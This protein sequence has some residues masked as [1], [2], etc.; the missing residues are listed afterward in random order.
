M[1]DLTGSQPLMAARAMMGNVSPMAVAARIA[2]ALEPVMSRLAPLRHGATDRLLLDEEWSRIDTSRWVP[3][4]HPRPRASAALSGFDPAGDGSYPSGVYSRDA[5]AI[6]SGLVIEAVIRVP[7]TL[8]Y[9][10]HVELHLISDT[11]VRN[12]AD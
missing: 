11:F 10:Q 8:P 2:S 3:F 12:I 1:L 4:G 6:G 5:F 9:W 7:I